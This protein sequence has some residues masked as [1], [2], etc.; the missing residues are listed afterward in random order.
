VGTE[1]FHVERPT[2]GLTWRNS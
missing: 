2:D 1:L